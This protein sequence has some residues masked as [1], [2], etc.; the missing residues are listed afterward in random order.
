ML[1]SVD[2]VPALAGK[3]ATGGR[4]NVCRGIV[5]CV[6][7][8]DPPSFSL[9]AAPA[10]ATFKRGASAPFTVTVQ[11][12]N[13]YQGAVTLSAGTLPAGITATFSRNPLN[14]PTTTTSTLTLKAASTTKRGTYNVWVTAAGSGLS[15]T[16]M[17][18][19]TI[20]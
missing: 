18:R 20:S 15:K 1:A 9:G 10:T 2:P 19:I 7:A 11:S 16:T 3:V 5:G 17:I 13:G 6:P 8:A 4:F 14:P 12:Q